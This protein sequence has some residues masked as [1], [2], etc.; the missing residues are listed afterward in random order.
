MLLLSTSCCGSL[1]CLEQN[2]K[3]FNKA[4]MIFET[5]NI[6]ILISFDPKKTCCIYI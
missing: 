4:N 6:N 1:N 2:E 3:T 5:K